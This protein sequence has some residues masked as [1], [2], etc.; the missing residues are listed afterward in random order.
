M[1][2]L[3]DE[4]KMFDYPEYKSGKSRKN[5]T[6]FELYFR[7]GN[8]LGTEFTMREH[9][10]V[11]YLDAFSM[12]DFKYIK[13]INKDTF[14]G[15]VQYGFVLVKLVNTAKFNSVRDKLVSELKNIAKDLDSEYPINRLYVIQTKPDG[16]SELRTI[17]KLKLN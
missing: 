11:S 3:L 8:M 7:A 13:K 6:L 2:D 17:T 5:A 10:F 14:L 15:K 16:T 4:D 1:A 9:M 12:R